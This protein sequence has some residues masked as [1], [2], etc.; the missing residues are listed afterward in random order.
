MYKL[1]RYLNEN[2]RIFFKVTNKNGHLDGLRSE[3]SE[4]LVSDFFFL[5]K[6]A[7]QAIGIAK[8]KYDSVNATPALFV[9]RTHQLCPKLPFSALLMRQEKTTHRSYH[10]DIFLRGVFNRHKLVGTSQAT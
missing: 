5:A 2:Q 6:Y 3:K 7:E 8:I 4:P 1:R 9:P 10:Y